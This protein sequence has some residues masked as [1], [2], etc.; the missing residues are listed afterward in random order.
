MEMDILIKD[1][2]GSYDGR[3]PVVGSHEQ[4]NQGEVCSNVTNE[5]KADG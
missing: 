5:P 3:V 1:G 4:D 2:M